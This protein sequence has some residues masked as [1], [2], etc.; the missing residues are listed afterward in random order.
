MSRAEHFEEGAELD[1][2]LPS[3]GMRSG[4]VEY[5][6]SEK[7]LFRR[8]YWLA[9]ENEGL[10]RLSGTSIKNI[11]DSIISSKEKLSEIGL[12]VSVIDSILS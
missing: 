12:Q 4:E 10:T 3:T 2:L 9:L 11:V 1:S 8:L 7:F 5:L 6:R